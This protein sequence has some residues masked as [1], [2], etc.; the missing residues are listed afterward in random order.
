MRNVIIIFNEH[1][2]FINAFLTNS[3]GKL[4]PWVPLWTKARPHNRS[5]PSLDFPTGRLAPL[6]DRAPLPSGRLS[7]NLPLPNTRQLQKYKIGYHYQLT[8]VIAFIE[9]RKMIVIA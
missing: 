7:T 4:L 2:T 5:N 6:N 3:W 8:A 1:A 9:S